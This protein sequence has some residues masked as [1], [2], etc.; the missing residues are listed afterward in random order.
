MQNALAERANI[1]SVITAS[2]G[3]FAQG[4]A[5]SA[6]NFNI[7][8]SAICPDYAPQAKING[9]KSL[10]ANVVSVPYEEWRD[11]MITGKTKRFEGH[12]IHTLGEYDCLAGYGVIGNMH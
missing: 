8:C 4:L 9:L 1:Q 12:F 11:V 10:G 6:K 5:W 3:N 2:S 7:S